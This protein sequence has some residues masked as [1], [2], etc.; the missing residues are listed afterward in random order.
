MSV[1]AG[2]AQAPQAL[3]PARNSGVGGSRLRGWSLQEGWCSF[4][5]GE[6]GLA[7]LD[8]VGGELGG[9][10][11]ADVADRVDRSGRDEPDVA[12]LDRGR[13]LALDLI[14]QGFEA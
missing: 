1:K 11:A 14:L 7:L 4:D 12:G 6:D 9:V 10:A 8:D 3:Q 5:Q 2:Q 13:G